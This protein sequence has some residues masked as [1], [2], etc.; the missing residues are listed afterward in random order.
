[1]SSERR[2]IWEGVYHS[3]DEAAADSDV[4][5]GDVWLGKVVERAKTAAELSRSTDYVAPVA[6]SYDYVLPVVAALIADDKRPVRILDFGG[7]L[8]ASYVPLRAMLPARFSFDFV[9]IENEAICLEGRRSFA[10]DS[11]VS[12][13]TDLPVGERFDIVHFG[14]SLHYVENWNELLEKI[15]GFGP[16]YL[17]FAELPAADNV[18]FVTAQSYYGRRIPVRFWN[19][20]EFVGSVDSLGFELVWKA[21]YRGYWLRVDDELPTDNFEEPY[22]LRYM[23]QFLFRR[24][25]P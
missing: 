11:T 25:G 6:Q 7:G 15:V 18:G 22:R 8:A 19:A 21:R 17:I 10:D 12:F 2:K 9:V 20:K 23:S 13:R 1:M 4:F 16:R 14:S 3:F 5:V 24:S